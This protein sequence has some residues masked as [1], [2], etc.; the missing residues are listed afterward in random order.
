[1]CTLPTTS[2][3]NSTSTPPSYT[4]NTMSGFVSNSFGP[5]DTTPMNTAADA[6]VPSPASKGGVR[7]KGS[8]TPEPTPTKTVARKRMVDVPTPVRDRIA[9]AT[10]VAEAA[11]QA[12]REDVQAA[13]SAMVAEAAAAPAAKKPK[14]STKAK[15]PQVSQEGAEEPAGAPVGAHDGAASEVKPKKKATTTKKKAAAATNKTEE[16]DGEVQ[17]QQA[18]LEG[19]GS[20]G[21]KAAARKGKKKEGEI[22]RAI[23]AFLFYSNATRAAVR[24]ANPGMTLPEAAKLIGA[25]WNQ[26]SPE[27]RRPYIELGEKEKVRYAE[28]VAAAAVAPF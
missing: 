4:C 10:I 11:V 24:E 27:D 26:L 5:A 2:L 15:K 22:K 19:G 18:E 9:A 1:M 7:S 21:G 13:S 14:R 3:H 28:E 17:Q 12:A 25:A 23:S 20:S 16:E 6:P 8:K